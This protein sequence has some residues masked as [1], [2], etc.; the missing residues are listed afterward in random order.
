MA[1]DTVIYPQD[2]F[3]VWGYDYLIQEEKS[4]C[5][6]L[7]SNNLFPNHEQAAS[8]HA[9]NWDYCSSSSVMQN[10]NSCYDMKDHWGT[11]SSPDDC[12]GGG[13]GGGGG[14][15]QMISS[16]LESP[17]CNMMMESHVGAALTT[18]TVASAG[19]RK[20]RRT[21][22]GKNKEELEN[23]RMTHITVERNRRK[24]MN[25]YLAVI[26]SLMPPSYVQRGDQASIIG[27]A[28]NFVK[29]LEQQLQTLEVQKRA[30]HQQPNSVNGYSPPPLP[31]GEFFTFPQYSMKSANEVSGN[32]G[33]SV[34]V[35]DNRPLA[36]AEIEVTMVESHAN[37]K[38]L[39]KKR[40]RQ[41]LKIV[42][43]L[44]C[45]WLTILHLN[46]TTVDQMVLYSLSVKLED[47]CQLSTVDEIADAVNCLLGRIE[48]EAL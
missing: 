32:G 36:M 4:L 9:N 7:E 30:M 5:G 45:L 31:F 41:L 14:G 28:I 17:H 8:V 38:I 12:T 42:A 13:S 18:N 2:Q 37:L 39:S 40:Y 19:R 1:L 6:F 26:R 43:G 25:E 35:A 22:S 16:E 15:D 3:G 10:H 24:Q 48:E 23:Q 44:Q 11:I 29:E 33:G 46:V 34:A 47:G 20:R 21:K 27:G